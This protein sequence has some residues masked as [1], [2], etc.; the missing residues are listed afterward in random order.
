MR[1]HVDILELNIAETSRK[2]VRDN[3]VVYDIAEDHEYL[4]EKYCCAG[5]SYDHFGHCT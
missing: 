1:F 3:D 5:G 4:T 2:L